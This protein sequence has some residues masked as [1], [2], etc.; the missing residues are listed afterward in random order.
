MDPH[1]LGMLTSIIAGKAA[2]K[3]PYE[4]I[5]A[6]YCEKF[7]GKGGDNDDEGLEGTTVKLGEAGPS[8]ALPP[9]PS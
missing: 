2:Y 8:S 1:Y 3:P 4:K 9:G 7:R 5:K 6:K